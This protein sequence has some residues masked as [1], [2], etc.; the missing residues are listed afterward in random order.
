MIG[1][2]KERLVTAARGSALLRA[3]ARAATH[4]ALCDGRR[5]VVVGATNIWL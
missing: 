2:R 4:L 5:T 3:S 1:R